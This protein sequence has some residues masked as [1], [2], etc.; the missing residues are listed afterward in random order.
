M[1]LIKLGLIALLTAVLAI[2]CSSNA[3]PDRSAQSGQTPC[4]P[5][6]HSAGETC[7]PLNIQRVVT[8]GTPV[9]ANALVLETKPVGGIFYFDQAPAY[10]KGESDDVERVGTG[11]QPNL[12]K[13]LALQPDLI[14]AMNEWNIPHGELTQI[15]PTVVDDWQ[16]YQSWKTH[17]DFVAQAL[18][19]THKAEQIWSSYDQRVQELK[20]ALG[21]AYQ[22]TTVSFIY[23]CCG[24]ISIDVK[25][26]F[27]GMILSDI[28][29]K[30]P[31]AQNIEAS[32]GLIILSEERLTDADG[33]IIFLAVDE[34]EDSEM[35]L[36]QLQ[37]NSIWS[38]LEAVKNGQV[39]PVNLATWRGGNPL[40]AEAVMDDLF[41][42]LVDGQ[43][44]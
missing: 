25:N 1:P 13:I 40:A 28:G 14:I 3:T 38:Q 11:E 12:E 21:D 44:P 23:L 18:G 39:Y 6:Q 35:M 20:S 2:G 7:V 37:Q 31:P 9:L 4:R 36:S 19:K 41:K 8:L 5:I 34:D 24:G 43:K 29:L 22:D 26:S 17:F 32:S 16:G 27:I 33:D 42:Y 15:A 30:R 10:L